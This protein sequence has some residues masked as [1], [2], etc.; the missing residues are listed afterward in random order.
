MIAIP[1][2]FC[3]KKHLAGLKETL[4]VTGNLI[5]TGFKTLN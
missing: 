4:T 1:G 5:M 2:L 3:Y